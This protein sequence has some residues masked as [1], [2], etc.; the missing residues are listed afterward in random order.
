MKKPTQSKRF[1]TIALALL[2]A[3]SAGCASFDKMRSFLDPGSNKPDTSESLSQQGLDHFNHGKYEKALE[4]FKKLKERYPFSQ[5]SLLAELKI[6]DSEYY[7]KNYEE[8][9]LLYREFEE[10]HPS[11]EAVPYVMFQVGMCYYKEI[12]TID[13]DSSGASNAIQAFSRQLKSFPVSP[14]TDEAQGRIMAAKNFL[15][16][17]EFYVATFYVKTKSYIEAMARLEYILATYPNSD[18]A[19]LA[20][21]LLTDLKAGNPPKRTISSWLPTFS[22]P[23]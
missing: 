13:R 14:Y 17:H 23:F 6:A 2:L 16:G 19:P 3:V 22:M 4:V 9:R 5:Y 12:D 18:V 10:Q 15:A 20:N 21:S 11:N 7:L 8:A 1:L